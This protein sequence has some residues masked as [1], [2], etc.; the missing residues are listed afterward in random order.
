MRSHKLRLPPVFTLAGGLLLSLS[1][2]GRAQPVAAPAPSGVDALPAYMIASAGIDNAAYLA[3]IKS[4]LK[5]PTAANIIVN[6]DATLDCKASS[7]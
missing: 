3:C 4:K 5:A 6:F 1:A 2:F 7:N